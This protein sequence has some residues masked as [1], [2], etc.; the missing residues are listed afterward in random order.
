ML[1]FLKSSAVR[2]GEHSSSRYF[3]VTKAFRNK[4]F[5]TDSYNNDIGI[6]RIQPI[7]KFNGN[8]GTPIF[9]HKIIF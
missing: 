5:T 9:L 6:L 7:V 2:L 4:Y 8:L 1:N 3:A